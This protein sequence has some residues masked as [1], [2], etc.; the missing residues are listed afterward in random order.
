MAAAGGSG[1]GASSSSSRDGD[2]RAVVG[3]IIRS[4]TAEYE[5]LDF[6]GKGTFGQVSSGA[7]E[8][9]P[10]GAV[11]TATLSVCDP[12]GPQMLE[13]RQRGGGGAKGAEVPSLVHQTGQARGRDPLATEKRRRQRP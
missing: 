5:V 12:V 2:Y 8:E 13:A 4:S 11:L 10:R 1:S 7:P 9:R 3:E 6:L